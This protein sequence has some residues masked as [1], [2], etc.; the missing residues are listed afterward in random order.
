MKQTSI[1]PAVCAAVAAVAMGIPAAFAEGT[2]VEAA[3]SAPSAEMPKVELEAFYSSRKIER[4]MVENPESVFGYEAE[5]EWRGLFLG[6]EANYDMTNVNGRR[7]RYNEI[8]PTAGYG[9]KFGDFSAKVAYIYKKCREC[10]G[11]KEH[12][13]E[14]NFELE[15]ETPWVTPFLEWNCD[16]DKKPGAMYGSVGLKREWEIAEWLVASA[17]GGIGAGNASR[18]RLDFDSDRCAF[19]DMHLGAELEIALCPN[20]KLVPSVDLYDQFTSAGRHAYRKGF[21]AVG[22]VKLSVEF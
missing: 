17:C 10:A 15:Y 2:S 20:V 7:G 9:A 8:S 4:G 18:N 19:R 1:R 22:G 3:E 21:V 6:V 14:V 12:T 13:Q 16:I 5:V 11:E